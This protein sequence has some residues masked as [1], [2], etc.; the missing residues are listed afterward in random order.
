MFSFWRRH[1]LLSELG[2]GAEGSRRRA[3]GRR[4][5]AGE[6]RRPYDLS[7]L[8]PVPLSLATEHL[9]PG[10]LTYKHFFHRYCPPVHGNAGSSIRTKKGHHLKPLHVHQTMIGKFQLGNDRQRQKG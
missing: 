2:E 6:D 9:F 8:F 3:V 10:P 7:S 1:K 4:Q 5:W